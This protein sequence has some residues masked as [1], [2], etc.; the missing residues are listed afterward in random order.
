MNGISL[1]AGCG[2]DTLGMEQAGINVIAYVEK[3]KVFQESHE[4]NFPNSELIGDDITKIPDAEFQKYE[5][6]VDIIF[7]GFPCQGFSHAG[8]K[9]ADDPRNTLF[10]EFVRAVK[11]IKPKY[12]VGENVKGLLTR[13]TSTGELY[14]DI[15]KNEFVNMGY[16]IEYKVLKAHDYNV[17]QKRERLI[18]IGTNQVKEL[19]FPEP[20]NTEPNLKNIVKFNMKGALKI[21]KSHYDMKKEVPLQ[22]I[23]VNNRNT[24]EENNPHPF[25]KLRGL[26]KNFVYKD[27]TY[28]NL[29]SFGKRSSGNNI[30]IIDI[31]KPSKTIIC[32]YDHQPRL[33]VPLKNINGYFLRCL[34]PDELK[35]IQGFPEDYTICGNDKQK[36]VQIGNAVPPPLIKV[37][38][39]A[40]IT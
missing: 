31:R 5:D 2:G 17:P 20:V 18:I 9:L 7:A 8:K 15:I 29:I 22:C 36:I 14:I 30:E 12:I 38:V 19:K 24:E 16:Y 13:K 37:I 26:V 32:T 27:K 6:N 10:R 33:F 21:E 23:R 28:P 4:A 11:L 25:L 35:Q 39:E 3:V 34:L 1:F 40:L